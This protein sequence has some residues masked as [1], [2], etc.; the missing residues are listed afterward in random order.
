[1]H[2]YDYFINNKKSP[3][4]LAC[5]S[6]GRNLA[7]VVQEMG[8]VI[9]DDE[10]RKDFDERVLKELNRNSQFYAPEVFHKAW[11]AMTWVLD[12]FFT[13]NNVPHELAQKMV[14]VFNQAPN[15][16]LR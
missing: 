3:I 7:E 12:S 15:Q 2:D 5:K 9:Y 6:G 4:A 1:M 13:T 8:M 11:Q 16:P 10:L 14:N